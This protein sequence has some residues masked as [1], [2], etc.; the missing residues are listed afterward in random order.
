M[1]K[2]LPANRREQILDIV[3]AESFARVTDMAHAL[4]VAPITVRRDIAELAKDGLVEQVRGGARLI[5]RPQTVRPIPGA[6]IGVVTP[7]LDYYWPSIIHGV[8]EAA[9]QTG[10]RLVLQGSTYAAKDNLA[11]FRALTE[12]GTASGLV[13]VPE[14]SGENSEDLLEFLQTLELPTVLMER[15]LR[16]HGRFAR[17]FDS[18]VTD[19][20]GGA[21]MA[22]RH[23]ASLGHRRLALLSDRE[24]PTQVHIQQGW[25]ETADDLEL[26]A[27]SQLADGKP[28]RGQA[29]SA[30]AIASVERFIDR[31]VEESVTGVLV[32]PDETALTVVEH[33]M[34]RGLDV[35]RDMSVITYDDEIANLSRPALTAVAPPKREL[36]AGAL[37]LVIDR[38]TA[39]ESPL[40]HIELQPFLVVRDSTAEPPSAG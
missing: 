39:P 35:P 25:Q 9:D 14:L 2:D 23:L 27:F 12:E 31:C 29:A 10:V 19:H 4:H 37:R 1:P 36:G 22:V 30:S 18:I 11:Q 34:R 3:R 32:H 15:Q 40:T 16:P 17:T 24:S 33:L 20:R 6:V 7:S 21:S 28:R 13:L 5:T 26:T 38:I 8:S